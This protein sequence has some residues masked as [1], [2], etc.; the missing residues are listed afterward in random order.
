MLT[1]I[2][3]L[4]IDPFK[5]LDSLECTIWNFHIH[6]ME[7]HQYAKF[8]LVQTEYSM[9]LET[10]K[11]LTGDRLQLQ[12]FLQP[13]DFFRDCISWAVM[14]GPKAN[15]RNT[16]T[17]LINCFESSLWKDSISVHSRQEV[18]HQWRGRVFGAV[19]GESQLI[20]HPCEEICCCF[21]IK[22]NVA[23]FVELR[24]IHSKEAITIKM[25]LKIALNVY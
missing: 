19:R 8:M 1:Y 14:W 23:L 9:N 3:P 25:V 2:V 10:Y 24:P 21:F 20:C 12:S 5:P 15:P 13:S 6:N 4:W 11:S 18:R 16:L 22:S 17:V 7:H